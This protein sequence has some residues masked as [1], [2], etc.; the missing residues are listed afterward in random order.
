MKILEIVLSLT[1]GGAERF[2]VDLSNELSKGNSVYLLTLKDLGLKD[3]A[4]YLKEVSENVHLV[5][6]KLQDGFNPL[7]FFKVWNAVKQINPD[8]VHIHDKSDKYCLLPM[9]FHPSRQCYVET[10][11]NDISSSYSNAFYKLLINIL[12]RL[13]RVKYVTISKTNHS[14]F[15]RFYPKV[16]NALIYNGRTKLSVTEKIIEVKEEIDHYKKDAN[17]KVLLHVGRC[18]EQ[19]NQM[20]LVESFKKWTDSGAN[21]VL[22]VCGSGFDSQLGDS[23]KQAAS[24]NIHFIG[25]RSN[26]ADYLSCSDA[27]VLSSLYE[28][29]PITVIEAMMMKVPILSTPVCGVVD[30]VESGRNGLISVDFSSDSFVGMLNDFDRESAQLKDNCLKNTNST[31]TMEYCC[32]MYEKFFKN[33]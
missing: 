1:S 7:Y 13:K 6:L 14:D 3:N 20:L 9:L 32:E 22:L 24:P 15:S 19:K 11:H 21:A 26:V 2:V 16:G 23:L 25:T 18:V 17:T 4:F 28:G 31:L 12:G 8:V 29:M 30:V 33:L 27:F 10:I 5:D